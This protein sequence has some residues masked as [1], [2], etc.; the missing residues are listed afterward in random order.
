MYPN[1]I[2]RA[3]VRLA[4]STCLLGTGWILS[5]HPVRAQQPMDNAPVV[6]HIG[7]STPRVLDLGSTAPDPRAFP[8]N[9]TSPQFDDS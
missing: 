1:T 4:L 2:S 5:A 9:W 6:V 7:D 3:A 8:A